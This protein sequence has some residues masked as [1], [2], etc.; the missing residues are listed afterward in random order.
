MC[1]QAFWGAVLLV[2]VTFCTAAAA[3]VQMNDFAYGARLAAPSKPGLV[4]II[5]PRRFHRNLA[6]E[7]GADIRVFT[8]DGRVV[9]HVL[10]EAASEGERGFQLFFENRPGQSYILA[11]GSR[12]TQA[13]T[14]PPELLRRVA[15]DGRRVPAARI[16]PRID[17]GGPVRLRE[18]AGSATGRLMS[19]STFLLGSVLLL[20][21]LVWWAVRRRLR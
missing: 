4:K 14:P 19:L 1:Q 2:S 13:P 11:Y 7:D 8:L 10:R 9:P 17:L 12:R 6:H 20:A 15:R 3:A 21:F 16:G 18:P 5:L